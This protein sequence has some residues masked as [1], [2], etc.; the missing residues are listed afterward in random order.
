[1]PQ[2]P[3]RFERLQLAARALVDE[4]T[5]RRFYVAPRSVRPAIAEQIRKAFAELNVPDPHATR[6]SK[7]VAK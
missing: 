2:V 4:R 7:A 6:A 5:I 1:M 3:S